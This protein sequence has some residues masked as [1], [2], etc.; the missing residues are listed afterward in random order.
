MIDDTLTFICH[1][2][3]E[4]L[5]Y[6]DVA[7]AV[8]KKIKSPAKIYRH[9]FKIKRPARLLGRIYVFDKLELLPQNT[10]YTMYTDECSSLKTTLERI[11]N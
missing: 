5:A 3:P 9:D 11:V 6:C 1:G 2:F 4:G 7:C 10:I 8:S